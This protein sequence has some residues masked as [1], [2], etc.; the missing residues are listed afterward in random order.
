MFHTDPVT[1]LAIQGF[2]H[3]LKLLILT[4][5]RCQHAEIH[6]LRYNIKPQVRKQ[7]HFRDARVPKMRLNRYYSR[8]EAY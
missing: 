2:E 3:V 8:H 1:L 4:I 6:E 7:S 5:Y